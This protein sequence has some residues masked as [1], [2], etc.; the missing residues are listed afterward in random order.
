MMMMMMMMMITWPTTSATAHCLLT[1][2]ILTTSCSLH[3]NRKLVAAIWICVL[4]PAF[5]MW[6][7]DWE[8]RYKAELSWQALHCQSAMRAYLKEYFLNYHGFFILIFNSVIIWLDELAFKDSAV[9]T[10]QMHWHCPGICV[11]LLTLGNFKLSF[12]M[13]YF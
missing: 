3:R 10:V 8:N 7:I 12:N 6:L 4:G 13:L 9:G 2:V 11:N 5:C 1:L